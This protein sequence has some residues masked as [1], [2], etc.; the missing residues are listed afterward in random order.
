VTPAAQRDVLYGGRP[1]LRVRL[2]VMELEDG[3]LGTSR[4]ARSDIGALVAVTARDP[5]LHA[6]RD[7]AR[8]D[9]WRS[10]EMIRPGTDGPRPRR[11]S[12]LRLLDLL[13][14][15]GDGAV[16]DRARIAVRNLAT[17]KVLQA[18]QLVVALLPDR[19]LDAITLGRRGLND[20]TTNCA[21]RNAGPKLSSDSK[22]FDG[23]A[24]PESA[25]ALELDSRA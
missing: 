8:R 10:D 12:P 16:E 25:P 15:E 18:T 6:V 2:K 23:D 11:R 19:E 17:E 7:V 14:Q 20:R 1:S 21:R 22:I 9:D 4:S 3:S 24:I 5:A 13:Q